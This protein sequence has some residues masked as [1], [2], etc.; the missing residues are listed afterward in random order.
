MVRRYVACS[1]ANNGAPSGGA[2]PLVIFTDEKDPTY[3]ASLVKALSTTG[4]HS[5]TTPRRVLLGESY[6][7]HAT[8]R[9]HGAGSGGGTGKSGDSG[10]AELRSFLA[11]LLIRVAASNDLR[12]DRDNC[13]ACDEEIAISRASSSLTALAVTE[14]LGVTEAGNSA[15]SIG[16][17]HKN[18]DPSWAVQGHDPA[19]PDHVPGQ[20]N[21]SAA[22]MAEALRTASICSTMAGTAVAGESALYHGWQSSCK[23]PCTV[24]GAEVACQ[25]GLASRQGT[26]DAASL[27]SMRVP[28]PTE[29]PPSPPP[30]VAALL[31]GKVLRVR[32]PVSDGFFVRA[33]FVLSQG[34]WATIARV[35]FFVDLHSATCDTKARN[36][37]P[38]SCDAYEGGGGGAGAGGSSGDPWEA[39][40]EPIG[41]VPK[42][43]LAARVD[44]SQMV[45][46]NA[47]AAW[48]ANMMSEPIYPKTAAEARIVRS[49]MAV[50]VGAWVRVTRA[51]HRKADAQWSQFLSGVGNSGVRVLG[52]HI[53]G[54]DKFLGMVCQP[55]KYFALIDAY[56]AAHGNA[57]VRIFLATDD[58]SFAR[59][60]V[61]RYGA[62]RVLQQSGG[63]LV[64]G[65]RAQPVWQKAQGGAAA[66]RKGT[67]V[68]LDA[69]L[70][71]R[72]DYLIKANSAV[73]EF[74]IYFNPKLINESYDLS[75]RDQPRPAWAPE[76]ACVTCAVATLSTTAALAAAAP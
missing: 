68:L 66:V 25:L 5:G 23:P 49:R 14:Q 9:L 36:A 57:T 24:L 44:E 31:R 42:A 46:L 32:S 33:L 35:P 76:A 64:R 40:F 69:I 62:E 67:E 12:M 74:A 37:T 28:L 2:L 1:L 50:K 6:T 8:H 19:C 3:L 45:E 53:R 10:E 26:S 7:Q 51:I 21:A 15:S 39:Y 70:L 13:A 52:V 47:R 58:T 16:L 34:E 30:S 63:A 11:T 43:Q 72:C 41:G 71:S 73:S 38:R 55:D 48:T 75:I 61:G 54:T 20:G 29:S 59:V 18:A 4:G 60:M 22:W 65:T 56:I 17:T 27:V